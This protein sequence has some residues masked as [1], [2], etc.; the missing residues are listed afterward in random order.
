MKIKD[1][2]KD[3]IAKTGYPLEI[4]IS[5]ILDRD[6]HVYNTEA[7]VDR[8]EGKLRDVDIRAERF[9]VDRD[10]L[11]W[12]NLVIECKKD[13]NFAWVFFTRPMSFDDS[14]ITGH[15]LDEL[16]IRSGSS[17]LP[18]L[19]EIFL[20]NVHP[21]YE[22]HKS[23]AVAYDAFCVKGKKSGYAM[24][25][26]GIFEA[27]NQL[28]K[29]ISYKN[30]QTF[31]EEERRGLIKFDIF[32]PCIIFDGKLFEAEIRKGEIKLTRRKH[33][34]LSTQYKPSYS[35]LEQRF[36]IDIVHRNYFRKY[37]SKVNKDINALEE[38]LGRNAMKLSRELK[39]FE[40][41][42]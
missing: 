31:K 12:S 6:W 38:N 21:H 14:Y 24:K 35:V 10:T 22:E 20:E 1:F 28:K 15:Y 33:I 2:L 19:W 18:Q 7:Y 4:E 5:S 37:L 25:K 23:V 32:F 27:Q 11:L 17:E 30:E 26:R 13:E 41:M 42:L 40:S 3:R 39:H 34:L 8:D 16:Q 29:Y 36:L 9:A